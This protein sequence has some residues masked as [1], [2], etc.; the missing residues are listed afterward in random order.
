MTVAVTV[1]LSRNS[2]SDASAGDSEVDFPAVSSVSS[3]GHRDSFMC[4]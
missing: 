4:Q 3:H 2:E 1:S